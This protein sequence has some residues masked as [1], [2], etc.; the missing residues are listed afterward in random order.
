MFL[1]GVHLDVD[2][3]GLVEDFGGAVGSGV[4]DQLGAEN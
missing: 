3:G 4:G 1:A 2:G